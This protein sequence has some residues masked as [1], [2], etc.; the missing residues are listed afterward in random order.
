MTKKGLKNQNGTKRYKKPDR[1]LKIL[2]T[3]QEP[4]Q[5]NCKTETWKFN[6][7]ERNLKVPDRKLM[8]LGTRQ[9]PGDSKN[10]ADP[11]RSKEPDGSEDLR[12]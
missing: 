7:P 1:N 4:G 3:K 6:E 2:G 5:P 8:T 12:N 11:W 9:E 10:Q